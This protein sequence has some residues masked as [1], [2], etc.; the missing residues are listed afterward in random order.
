MS[1]RSYTNERLAPWRLLVNPSIN[2][3]DSVAGIILIWITLAFSDRMHIGLVDLKWRGHHTPYIVYLSRYFT[4]EGHGVTFITDE[5]HPRLDELPDTEKLHVRTARFSRTEKDPGSSLAAS[6]HEQWVRVRQLRR[7]FQLADEADVDVLHSLYFDRTQVPLWI[8]STLTRE[9]SLPFV[10]TLHR[11][12]FTDTGNGGG[13]KWL[14]QAAT[15][16]ALDSTLSNRTVDYLTVHADSIRDRIID[17]VG[18]ASRD[19]TRTVPAPTPELNV[20]ASQTE[21]RETLGLPTDTPLLLFF[22]G[23]RYE[24]GPDLLGKAM[25]ELEQPVTV[26]FAGSGADFTQRHVDEWKQ[27]TEEPVTVVDRIGFVPEKKVEYYFV[28]ADA[29]VLP[30]R[31]TRGISGPLRRACMANTHIIG[32]DGSDIGALIEKNG[33]G[34]TFSHESVSSL[35][36]TIVEFLSDPARYPTDNVIGFAEEQYWRNTGKSLETLYRKS[37][38]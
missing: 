38:S 36:E 19:N 10:T 13:A 27:E 12:M 5:N 20:S 7:I 3:H 9:P 35:R 23:L 8:A 22:G 16:M 2:G 26:V 24:K 37:V 11:D 15:R 28:A 1:Q 14:T 21:A 17:C 30:Y 4:E 29:L 33:L 25:Q 32:N 18:A 34:H 31:R 6:L